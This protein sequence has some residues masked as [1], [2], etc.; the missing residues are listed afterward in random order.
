MIYALAGGLAFAI[1]MLAVLFQRYRLAE[2]KAA[3]QN[4]LANRYH[5]LMRE[6]NDAVFVIDVA[7]G[8]ILEANQQAARW[9]GYTDAELATKKVF[10]I[11]PPDDIARSAE[12]VAKVWEEKG[13]IFEDLPL[14][15]RSGERLPVECSAKVLAFADRPSVAIYAR[16][17]RERLRLQNEILMQKREIEEK[18]QDLTDSITYARRIQEAIL[19]GTV[20]IDHPAFSSFVNYEPRDIVSGDFFWTLTH[21][22]E[23]TYHYIAVA[24]CTGHGVP[25]AF[26]SILGTTL[27]TK[28]VRERGILEPGQILTELD[29]EVR[30][31][32][33]QEHGQNQ[34]DT[35]DGMDIAL[36][37]L[38]TP[39]ASIAYAGAFRSLYW[40]R[41]NA[42]TG[43]P[44]LH[45]FE[46][47]RQA[48]GGRKEAN[49]SGFEQHYL[50]LEP[51]DTIYL[52][53]DGVTDQF[54]GPQRRKFSYKRLQ[55]LLLDY[56]PQ[57]MPRQSQLLAQVCAD[58]QGNLGQTDDRLLIG[59]RYQ[60]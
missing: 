24:D 5:H 22:T 57:S 39:T 33:K 13:L 58:W 44:E 14:Y 19:P 47:T 8:N 43:L 17:I 53:T 59:L 34:S 32:L 48:V 35:L 1:T 18:N 36:C 51:N 29:H 31:A 42:S 54:G 49:V 9:L 25:G 38:H 23:T 50:A 26:M 16:D 46:A 60:P 3:R 12:I 37:R 15:T 55:A 45:T 28:I 41:V 7:N 4:A 56:H 52:F 11:Y 40:V 20:L 27:L 2:H 6:V 10:D 21:H 30:L